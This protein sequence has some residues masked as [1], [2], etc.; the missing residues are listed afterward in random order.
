VVGDPTVLSVPY[1]FDVALE[2][3]S[4]AVL[5]IGFAMLRRLQRQLVEIEDRQQP[6][7]RNR[8]F[9]AKAAN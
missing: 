3:G 9:P 5:V 1:H 7:A 8:S 2:S 4:R 6:E